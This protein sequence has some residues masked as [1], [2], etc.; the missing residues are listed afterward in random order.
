MNSQHYTYY[1]QVKVW[2]DLPS[3][4]YVIHVADKLGLGCEDV[5]LDLTSA[6]VTFMEQ[7]IYL[8]Q[9]YGHKTYSNISVSCLRITKWLQLQLTMPGSHLYNIREFKQQQ[10]WQLRKHHLKSEFALPQT[11]SHLFHLV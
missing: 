8:F 5:W 11:L 6:L 2:S 10:R 9:C 1:V 3:E 7:K 4:I